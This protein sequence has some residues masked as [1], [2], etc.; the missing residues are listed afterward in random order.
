M[1]F[2]ARRMGEISQEIMTLKMKRLKGRRETSTL[3]LFL[4]ERKGSFPAL[5][6][7]QEMKLLSRVSR[8]LLKHLSSHET[9]A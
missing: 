8:I 2:M 4:C 9:E 5:H 6:I 1:F 7:R 3:I